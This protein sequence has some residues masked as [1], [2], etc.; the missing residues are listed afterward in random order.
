MS[1]KMRWW[2]TLSIS[3]SQGGTFI[4]EAIQSQKTLTLISLL[5]FRVRSCTLLVSANIYHLHRTTEQTLFPA[6][7]SLCWELIF[8]Q[9]G[10]FSQPLSSGL[11]IALSIAC[12]HR[13]RHSHPQ[14][15][16]QVL[17]LTCSITPSK[18]Q[19]LLFYLYHATLTVPFAALGVIWSFGGQIEMKS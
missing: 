11:C 18:W 17:L 16:L 9:Q 14:E 8:P 12:L 5:I 2:A 4:S 6:F 15:Q 1:T 19:T 7:L 13:P 10:L 3:Q